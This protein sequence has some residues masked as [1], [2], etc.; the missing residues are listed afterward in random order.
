MDG[1][2][3]YKNVQ[4]KRLLLYFTFKTGLIQLCYTSVL[5]S[6][7]HHWINLYFYQKCNNYKQFFAWSCIA[8]II[9]WQSKLLQK[10]TLG[11]YKPTAISWS[12]NK[13]IKILFRVY[14]FKIRIKINFEKC[15][16]SKVECNNKIII[17]INTAKNRA[18]VAELA[19][20]L[21]HDQKIVGLNPHWVQYWLRL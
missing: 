6:D 11:S 7:R 9:S 16:R 4:R 12:I 20:C 10:N 21:P 19:V 1:Q 17:S 8:I 3:L 14:D 5:S 2:S 15:S 13:K 18:T